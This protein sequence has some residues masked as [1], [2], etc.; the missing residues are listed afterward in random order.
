LRRCDAA[1]PALD[2]GPHL[3]K[4]PLRDGEAFHDSEKSTF[5]GLLGAEEA[6]FRFPSLP[7]Q[8]GRFL[9]AVSCHPGR[10]LFGPTGGAKT[11]KPP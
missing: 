2:A 8:I 11:R 3:F 9:T 10:P 7:H 6:P 5:G 1:A 4:L